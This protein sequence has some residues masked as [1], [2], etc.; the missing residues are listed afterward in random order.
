MAWIFITAVVFVVVFWL[1]WRV[2]A[3]GVG[4]PGESS[5]QQASDTSSASEGAADE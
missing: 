5:S 1:V 2:Y 4:R 3:K